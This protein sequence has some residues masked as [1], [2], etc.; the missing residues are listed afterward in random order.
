MVDSAS[1]APQI[2]LPPKGA[3]FCHT[4][5]RFLV[6]RQCHCALFWL[7]FNSTAVGRPVIHING[8]QPGFRLF[9][10]KR[11]NEVVYLQQWIEKGSV[12]LDGK[13]STQLPSCW[14]YIISWM[15]RHSRYLDPS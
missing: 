12:G 9:P 6:V 7:Y 15:V 11:M 14:G 13:G 8:C 1:M 3:K 10:S 5:D 2:G 4:S